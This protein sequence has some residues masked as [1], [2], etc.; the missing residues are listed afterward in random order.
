MRF[1]QESAEAMA[2]PGRRA[3]IQRCSSG[4]LFQLAGFVRLFGADGSVM[5]RGPVPGGFEYRLGVD[6]FSTEGSMANT[7][8]AVCSSD[9]PAQG[10]ACRDP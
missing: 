7:G 4:C 6:S 1:A 8:A 9:E 10:L 5:G 3:A 2:T